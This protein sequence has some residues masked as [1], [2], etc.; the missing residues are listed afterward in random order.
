MSSAFTSLRVRNYRL[1]ASGQVVSNTG[2]WMQRTAQDWLVLDLSR[3]SGLALGIVT[4]L[5][6]LPVL[7]FGLYGG[8]LADRYDK[9]KLLV[10][11]QVSMGLLALLL[12]ILDV[13]G[14]VELWHVYVL[15]AGLGLATAFDTPTRQA[16]VNEMV[17]ER[18]LPNA[19]SLNSATFNSARVVGPAV[20]G[21]LIS[22]VGTGW[23]FLLNAASFVAVIVGLKRMRAE[24][25]R[26]ANRTPRAKGQLR[27]G[28]SYVRQRDDLLLPIVLVGLVGM[29]G[30]NFQVTIALMAKVTFHRGADSYGLLGSLLAVGS[31][32]GSLISAQRSG[33]GV[34]PRQRTYL[35]AA[36]LFGVFEA[37]AGLMPTYLT[38]G[39][40]LL[41]T[42][43]A[44][45]LFSTAANTTVQ[46][47]AGPQFRGRVMGLY[48]LV[49]LGGT[50]IGAPVIGVLAQHLG[51]RSS[52][53]VGGAV[54]ALSAVA[55]AAYFARRRLVEPALRGRITAAEAARSTE[56]SE[57][58]VA[59]GDA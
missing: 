12:G 17:G 15:A 44:A 28:L 23:V 33:R 22:G 14:T 20:A 40:M 49:F 25:L 47:A 54:S 41:P 37:V 57:E 56:M 5:Q 34:A 36:F 11:T 42:G 52:L 18:D 48:I 4:G 2:T 58:L 8:V 13:T 32:V 50:P 16:F 27:E 45:L 3:N 55:C 30:L 51:P 10:A 1:F 38:F 9:R 6:F 19:V 53:T 39:L 24:E 21:L 59:T 46:L 29:F 7:L 31:L 43:L 35:V 26:P